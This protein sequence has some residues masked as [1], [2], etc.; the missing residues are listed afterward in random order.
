MTVRTRQKTIRGMGD[1]Y[2]LFKKTQE[3]EEKVERRGL[4]SSLQRSELEGESR[5]T[6]EGMDVCF[7]ES[8]EDVKK[9]HL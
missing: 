9:Q 5:M 6:Q 4:S 1:R 3:W 7:G 8:E 2:C